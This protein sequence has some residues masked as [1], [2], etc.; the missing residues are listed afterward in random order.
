M[1]NKIQDRFREICGAIWTSRH[2]QRVIEEVSYSFG[3]RPPGSTAL[4]EARRYMADEFNAIG[5]QNVHEEPVPVLAWEPGSA[6]LETTIPY[7]KVFD[8]AHQVH[9]AAGK[10][11]A[12]LV[13][14]GGASTAELDRLGTKI[15]GA[16]VLM[17]DRPA[18]RPAY[19]PM[20]KRVMDIEERG[21]RIVVVH[22]KNRYVGKKVE[23]YGVT[24]D[25]PLPVIGISFEQAEELRRFVRQGRTVVRFEAAGRSYRA[26]CA[27]L[28]GELVPGK[29]AGAVDGDASRRSGGSEIIINSS[30]LDTQM[31]AP[32]A[33][34]DLTGVAAML[35]VARALA[36]YT[37]ELKRTL[38]FIAYTGEEFGFVGSKTYVE[39]HRDELDRIR[40]VLNFDELTAETARGAA[41]MWSEAMR[42]YIEGIF[43]Q[44][45]RKLEVR[46]FFCFSNIGNRPPRGKFHEYLYGCR[47]WRTP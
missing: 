36:P 32:G 14:A 24:A 18:T 17:S 10:G 43:Q 41:V 13:D 33:F 8:A 35:E 5:L 4:K 39:Q 15:N 44:T 37:D 26:E 46:S 6:H 1:G 40:F 42:D 25:A 9:T 45:A 3:P 27:N 2:P 11:E 19:E 20:L 23:L 31:Q 47:Q 30:H 29:S 12:V 22:N 16:A 34:D 28:I 7:R 21:G 38:R